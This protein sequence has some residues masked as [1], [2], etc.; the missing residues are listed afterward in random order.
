MWN[1]HVGAAAPALVRK[2]GQAGGEGYGG[3]QPDRGGWQLNCSLMVEG[4]RA[5]GKRLKWVFLSGV[6]K[7]D[8]E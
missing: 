7:R 3:K 1:Q 8:S 4:F 6:K 5:P 2:T